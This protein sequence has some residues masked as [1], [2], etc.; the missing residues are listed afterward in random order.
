MSTRPRAGYERKC[1]TQLNTEAGRPVSVYAEAA[2]LLWGSA[3]QYASEEFS[4]LNVDIWDGE[5]PDLPIVIG[6]TAYSKCVG[7]TRCRD[8][9][10]IT[11]S[12]EIFNGSTRLATPGALY[13]SDVLLHEMTHAVLHL[14]GQT[15]NHNEDPWC[16]EITRITPLIGLDEIIAEPVNPRRVPNPARQLDPTAPKTVPM[17]IARTGTLTRGQLARW[18]LSIRPEGY[19]PAGQPLPVDTY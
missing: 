5:L 9:P 12:S 13:V 10:R 15:A 2:T 1:N 8:L 16:E 18:P 17:R 7:V 4:R 11:L 6:I 19:Y 3:G 14:R